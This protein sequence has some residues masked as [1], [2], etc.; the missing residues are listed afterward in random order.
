M[1]RAISALALLLLALMLS[2]A[3]SEGGDGE[4]ADPS[5]LRGRVV[6]FA[7]SSLTE[8]FKAIGAAFEAAHPG[9]AVEFNFASSSALATQIEQAAPADVFASA[10]AAQMQRLVESGRIE[11]APAPFTRNSLVLVV[12]RSS[13]PTVRTPAD[14]ARPGVKLVL[15][16]PDVPV[17]AYAREVLAKLGAEPGYPAGFESAALKNIVSNEANVRAVLAKVELGEA[18]AGIVY[19]TD[20]RAAADRVDV[21][22]LPPAANVVATYPIGTVT[23]GDT[24]LASAFIEYV[25]GAEGQALLLA[26]GFEP[27]AR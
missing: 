26:A 9:V 8:S 13:R 15:A 27:V 17:G 10:D 16:A 7:A 24:A 5:S 11:R 20:A 21:I 18:D 23:G 3:C 2:A 22:E 14:L 6:V 19:R 4:E 1:R 12:P 25:R